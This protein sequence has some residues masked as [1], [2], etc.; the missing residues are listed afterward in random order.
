MQDVFIRTAIAGDAERFIQLWD[1]LQ[2]E[3]D[4][5]LFEHGLSSAN[6]DN[7]SAEKPGYAHIL[8]LESAGQLAG[9]CAVS[10]SD[11]NALELFIALRQSH[12]G[13]G[14]GEK[15]LREMQNWATAN[16][17]ARLRLAVAASNHVALALYRKLGFT[18]KTT[19]S[20]ALKTEC[21][22]DDLHVMEKE[23]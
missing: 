23:L 14:W 2:T 10:R 21:G 16:G 6:S 5:L 22:V 12:R 1:T 18:T 7:S 15:L 19:E 3:A 4:G 9:F 17:V 20:Q 13:K 11:D 8:F